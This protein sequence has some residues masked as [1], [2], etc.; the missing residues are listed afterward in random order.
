MT[1]RRRTARS[2]GPAAGRPR[3][4]WRPWEQI[5]ATLAAGAQTRV[6]LNTS[7]SWPTL[8]ALGVIGDYTI[9]RLVGVVSAISAFAA[10]NSTMD[11]LVF[12]VIVMEDDALAAGVAPD[13]VS[14]AADWMAFG[15]LYVAMHGT[16]TAGNHPMS[17][18]ALDNRSMRKVNENHQSPVL[19]VEAPGNN[20][21]SIV[22]CTSGRMLVSHG[23]R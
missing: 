6:P 11:R 17:T 20:I 19:V 22:F 14:D 4:T 12:G 5:N 7:G 8:G 10:E 18:F 2:A 23:R 9:R 21:S 3:Y 13:P 16:F 15:F 1:T